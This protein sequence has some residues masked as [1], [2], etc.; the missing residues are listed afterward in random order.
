MTLTDI[1]VNS[2]FSTDEN[3]SQD[4]AVSTANRAIALIN[5]ECDTLFPKFET[6]T[7]VYTYMPSN[8]LFTLLSPYISYTIK[9]NDTSL[10]EADRYLDEFYKALN[11]FKDKLGTLIAEYD[12]TDPESGI[13]P[14]LVQ[15]TGFGGVYTIDTTEAINV[16]WFGNN[17]NGGDW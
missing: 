16:G 4:I 15:E 9:M 10:S 1:L 7:D 5:T 17:S 13:S 14:S 6:F 11:R 8:W 2:H 12:E 3:I